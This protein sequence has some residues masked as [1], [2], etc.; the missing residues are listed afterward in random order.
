MTDGLGRR[1]AGCT[2]TSPRRA[3]GGLDWSAAQD[4]MYALLGQLARNGRA[5][6]QVFTDR[7]RAAYLFG[8]RHVLGDGGVGIV[9]AASAAAAGPD[10]VPSAPEAAARRRLARRLG[11]RQPLRRGRR[12]RGRRRRPGGDRRGAH[13]RCPPLRRRP[14]PAVGRRRRRRPARR[15]PGD[16]RQRARQPGPRR[17]PAH[18]GGVRRHRA[19]PRP[20]SGG[21]DGR[22]HRCAASRPGRRTSW[23]WRRS[24]PNGSRPATSRPA[25]PRRT[26]TRRCSDAARL[27]GRFL[28]HVGHELERRGRRSDD[29]RSMW[30]GLLGDGAKQVGGLFGRSG[31]AV[32]GTVVEPAEH[33]GTRRARRCGRGCPGRRRAPGDAGQRA[34]GVPVVPRAARRRGHHRHRSRPNLLDGGRLPS[35]NDLTERLAADGPDDPSR[36]WT[37][38][39]VLQVLDDGSRTAVDVDGRAMVDA[40]KVVQLEHYRVL[41]D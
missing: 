5:G 34:A 25:T 6:R 1:P 3:T 32:V 27:E 17:R 20:R 13:R 2:S 15:A 4:P 35:Y 22:R 29:V 8:E 36:A 33:A 11:V 16:G 26:S 9:T 21:P 24:P 14:R 41:E 37:V 19:R 38:G 39:T 40:M 7:D 31:S 30:I 10:V 12:R 18:V 23:V 28:Q